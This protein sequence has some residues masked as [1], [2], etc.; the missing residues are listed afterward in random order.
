MAT[1]IERSRPS[2]AA[3][4]PMRVALCGALTLAAVSAQAAIWSDTYIGWRYGTKYAE[5]YESNDISKNIFMLTNTSGTKYGVNFFNVDLLLSD[6]KD[7]AFAGSKS[8][9]QETYIV[10]RFTLDIGKVRG[11]DIKFKGIRGVGLTVGFDYNTKTDAG[12]NS[13]KRMLLAGPAVM[14]DVPGFLTVSLVELYESNAPYSTYFNSGVERYHYDP[15]PMLTGAWGI[16]IGTT[17][18]AFEG[19]ANWIA[20]KGLNEY[21][22]HTKPEIN[23]DMEL[24]YDLGKA[25]GLDKGKLKVGPEFHYWKNKFGN[26]SSIPLTSGGPGDGAFAKTPEIRVEW[27]F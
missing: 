19:F 25:M 3:L 8:G 12:Y 6:S 2:V 24:M 16:P 7:P 15:H 26:D 20:A 11:Q 9:A 18:L 10:E 22:G 1:M 17:G 27:H 23:I 5:P 4:R 14:F 13:K 21:G